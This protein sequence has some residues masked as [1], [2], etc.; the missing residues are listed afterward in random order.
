MITPKHIWTSAAALVLAGALPAFAGAQ[1]VPDPHAGH[2]PAEAAAPVT[3]APAPAP[4]T[5]TAKPN[6]MMSDEPAMGGAM[7]MMK[8]M[9]GSGSKP[10]MGMMGGGAMPMG[11]DVEGR[12]ASLKTELK[13]TDPQ[14]GAWNSFADVMRANAKRAGQVHAGMMT[15]LNVA[16]PSLPQRLERHERMLA[17]GLDNFRAMKPALVRLYAGL[18]AEQK[19]S[20]DRLLAHETGM[21]PG[22]QMGGMPMSDMSRGMKKQ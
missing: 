16:R 4:S 21:M 12:I 5:P 1:S 18:S 17:V 10:M 14:A 2:H 8:D 3:P 6:G 9:G 15:P 7:G 11:A 20:A 19:S 13:I 22:M